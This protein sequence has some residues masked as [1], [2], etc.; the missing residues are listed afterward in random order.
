MFVQYMKVNAVSSIQVC[1]GSDT[2]HN[3]S[4]APLTG[5]HSNLVSLF[6]KLNVSHLS[7]TE[8]TLT[9]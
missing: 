9:V 7:D 6:Y 1:L 5:I 3:E 2:L 4:K 8:I